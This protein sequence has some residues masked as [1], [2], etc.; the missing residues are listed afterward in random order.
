M[1]TRLPALALP[2]L[3]LCLIATPA[4]ATDWGSGD[5]Y[6][7]RTDAEGWSIIEPGQVHR[8]IY[9]SS[10]AGSD[11]NSGLSPDAPVATWNKAR[12]LLRQNSSDWIL[13][14]RGDTFDGV[15]FRDE[16]R[17]ESPLHPIVVGSYGEGPRPVLTGGIK[18][19]SA[20]QGNAVFR[21]LEIRRPSV[22]GG[23]A[24]DF[25]GN[26]MANILIE[27][28]LTDGAA[29]RIQG[30]AGQNIQQITVR[31]TTI[32]NA[33]RAVQVD[34][35]SW[36]DLANRCQGLFANNT[37]G[38]LVEENVL[39][40]NG[41]SEGYETDPT[42]QA[43]NM[44][45][46]NL[47]L[48]SGNRD[49]TVRDNINARAGSQALRDGSGQFYVGNVMIANN[50]GGYSADDSGNGNFSTYMDNVLIHAAGKVAE[51]IGGRGWGWSMSNV[52][53][54]EAIRNIFAHSSG[55]QNDEGLKGLTGVFVEDYVRYAWQLQSNINPTG[56][57]FPDPGRTVMTYDAAFGTG[58]GTIE[59]F[60]LAAAQQ[61]QGNWS[62]AFTA[63]AMVRYFQEGFGIFPGERTANSAVSFT[64]G[65]G[66]QVRWDN[67]RNWSTQD[68]PLDGDSVSLAGRDV[69]YAGTRSLAGLDLA[70]GQLRVAQ[71]YLHAD[72]LGGAGGTVL[73]DRAGQMEFDNYS[74]AGRLTLDIAQGRLRNRGVATGL[75][76]IVARD[77]EVELAGGPA[78]QTGRL[79]L[80]NGSQLDVMGTGPA[81]G[82][83]GDGAGSIELTDGGQV[84]FVFDAA[85]VSP[86]AELYNAGAVL[87]RFHANADGRGGA[88]LGIDLSALSLSAGLHEF[89]LIDVDE[90]LG[91]FGHYDV[92]GIGLNNITG[93]HLRLD[94]DVDQAVLSV[95]VGGTG[96]LDGFTWELI[97]TP[98]LL[99]GDADGN[100]RVDDADLNILLGHWASAGGWAEGDFTG[101]GQVNDADLNLLL[102]HWA[103]GPAIPEPATLALLALA[104]L[105]LRRRR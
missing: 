15:R 82:Y 10:S 89:V 62:D 59:A 71:G 53:G 77:G 4:L 22:E 51:N 90:L 87:S 57:A 13:L 92:A 56:S 95:D 79:V 44:F 27:N 21:D 37:R 7:F 48:S 97:G 70:G 19:W 75:M 65:G 85:G 20:N 28:C 5:H 103:T 94:Q 81:I 1:P 3:L 50:I 33:H 60:I 105:G 83:W 31:R 32:T 39:D 61:Q 9:V 35:K 34:G 47:Y 88:T 96:G 6:T 16:L 40:H 98:G 2:C 68:L 101:D 58:A 43:P 45:S 17:G 69:N 73:L 12:A 104:G 52:A 55:G 38:L 41:W 99:L 14:K 100:G 93:A 42:L 102:S 49:L 46:H 76:T 24:I 72:T 36:G 66:D 86:I 80:G 18:L 74:G 29:S 25:L 23:D 63:R 84:R 64:A 26:D 78:G 8:T 91:A 54:S 67:V 11:S 30:D